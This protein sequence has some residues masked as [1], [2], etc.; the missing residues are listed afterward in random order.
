MIFGGTSGAGKTSSLRSGYSQSFLP[1]M[2][3][4][5]N[6]DIKSVIQQTIR[7]PVVYTASVRIRNVDDTAWV[8]LGT[9]EYFW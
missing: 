1:C 3:S 6:S 9:A 7:Q 2:A 8:D 5:G 4:V